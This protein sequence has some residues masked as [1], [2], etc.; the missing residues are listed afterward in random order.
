MNIKRKQLQEAF[1]N[2]EKDL[3]NP[4][5]EPGA[6][7]GDPDWVKDCTDY[8]WDK[9]E[10]IINSDGNISDGFINSSGTI[11]DVKKN[12]VLKGSDLISDYTKEKVK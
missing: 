3:V 6:E 12:Q 4:E 1:E 8:L 7:I 10:E 9:L 11:W 5:N 2:W